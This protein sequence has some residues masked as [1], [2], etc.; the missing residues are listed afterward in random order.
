LFTFV[1]ASRGHLCDSTAFLFCYGHGTNGQTDG[2]MA[3]LFAPF[4]RV[5]ASEVCFVFVM[6]CD[7]TSNFPRTGR[8]QSHTSAIVISSVTIMTSPRLSRNRSTVLPSGVLRIWEKRIQRCIP[9][10]LRNPNASIK[11]FRPN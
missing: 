8:V 6:C 10:N 1:G 4:S 2:R 9:H 5:S 11:R 3:A 7:E